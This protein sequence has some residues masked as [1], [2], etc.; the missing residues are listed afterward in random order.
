MM[1]KKVP[2]LKEEHIERDAAVLLAE[3]ERARG[4]RVVRAVP[5]EDIIEKHLKLGFEFDDMHRLFAVSAVRFRFRTGHPRCDVLS[6]S[7]ASS[8]T[9]ASILSRTRSMEGRYRFT[10]AHEVGH[11]RLHR[12]LFSRTRRRFRCSTNRRRPQLFA[13]RARRKSPSS[14]R[15]ISMRRVC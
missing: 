12:H 14:G 4:V 1:P 9:S 6:M 11:W 7:A 3:F 10:L 2:Y 8:S 15:R 13:V 5:I